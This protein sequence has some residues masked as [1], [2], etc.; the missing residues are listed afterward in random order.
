MATMEEI[1]RKEAEEQINNAD[2][3][4]DE[5]GILNFTLGKWETLDYPD[6]L[7]EQIEDADDF[8]S[9]KNIADMFTEIFVQ[10]IIEQGFTSIF[11][12][13]AVWEGGYGVYYFVRED[14]DELDDASDDEE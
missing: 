5:D 12:E 1:I 10:C 8:D 2:F 3:V 4:V 9:T 6:F 13:D 7:E 11:K 14:V